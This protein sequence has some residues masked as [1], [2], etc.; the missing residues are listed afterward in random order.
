ME[1]MNPPQ[2][3][4][5]AD[6]SKVLEAVTCEDAANE[7][8]LRMR[9]KSGRIQVEC[10]FHYARLGK[11]DQNLGNCV[12]SKNNRHCTC[13]A[14]GGSGN[15]IDMVMAYENLSFC[16]ATDWIAERLAPELL[17]DINPEKKEVK[18]C[19]FSDEEF[20]IIGI[21]VSDVLMPVGMAESKYQAKQSKARGG[22][23]VYP[24]DPDEDYVL[25]CRRGRLS[26]RDIF[27]ENTSLFWSIVEP[28]AM[29]ACEIYREQ[30][31]SLKRNEKGDNEL[32][33]LVIEELTRKLKIAKKF[34]H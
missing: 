8:G 20:E 23:I 15:A 32:R 9:T 2:G 29:E 17:R 16:E 18:R 3:A 25:L 19:P 6:R 22:E 5:H 24:D 14:C 31:L 21:H 4:L 13:Y 11:M 10:P 28:K 12:L 7:L 1:Q 26:I 27:V 34:V 30:I 33:D